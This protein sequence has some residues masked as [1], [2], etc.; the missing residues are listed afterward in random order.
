MFE[1]M[2]VSD[3]MTV[4]PVF[5]TTDAAVGDA[6]LALLNCGAR[7]LP[8]LKDGVLMGVVS[9]RDLRSGTPGL[10]EVM[11]DPASLLSRL[12]R[13]VSEL[14]ST[15][16]LS[17]TPGDDLEDAVDLLIEHRVGA[18][19]IVDPESHA[20]VGILSYLDA[21]RALRGLAWG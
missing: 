3:V 20:L 16:V 18:L 21:L 15:H 6:V 12:S 17:M 11:E 5:V 14:M 13:P 10:D 7:H 9:D 4:D 2:L 1:P 19:P 8:V